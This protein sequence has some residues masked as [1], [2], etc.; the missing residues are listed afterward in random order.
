MDS[1]K[2][3]STDVPV[4][5]INEFLRIV[6]DNRANKCKQKS[7]RKLFKMQWADYGSVSWINASVAITRIPNTT[8]QYA[9]QTNLLKEDGWSMLLKTKF[10]LENNLPI[11][12]PVS[13]REKQPT[14]RKKKRQKDDQM[15]PAVKLSGKKRPHD[16][17]VSFCHNHIEYS[18]PARKSYTPEEMTARFY[19]AADYQT[20]R[21]EAE[22]NK[23]K[24]RK[25][26][27]SN[28]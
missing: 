3:L 19:T 4:K 22:R 20:F 1:T 25:T 12:E 2:T 7:D 21:E 9:V 6:G 27:K 15:K 11:T 13:L 24:K 17:T 8:Y 16:H 5:T 28:F 14:Q 18:V 10:S 23:S 26:K